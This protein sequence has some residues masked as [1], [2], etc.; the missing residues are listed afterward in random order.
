MSVCLHVCV[1][2]CRY[3]FL[4]LSDFFQTELL[5]LVTKILSCFIH[6]QPILRASLSASIPCGTH[7]FH[8]TSGYVPALTVAGGTVFCITQGSQWVQSVKQPTRRGG[9]GL[10]Q[11]QVSEPSH[12]WQPFSNFSGYEDSPK[13]LLK[14]YNFR[15]QLQRYLSAWGRVQ[16]VENSILRSTAYT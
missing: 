5:N 4:L 1:C 2:V 16:A 7:L 13:W 10:L 14:M 9:H 3:V 6:A 12:L 8:C 11:S 15:L